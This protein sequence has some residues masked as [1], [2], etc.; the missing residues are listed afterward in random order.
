VA[1]SCSCCG[2]A[3]TH[4]FAVSYRGQ[5]LTGAICEEH[6]NVVARERLGLRDGR[7]NLGM[8]KIRRALTDPN[9]N[10]RFQLILDLEPLEVVGE[11][12]V[13]PSFGSGFSTRRFRSMSRARRSGYRGWNGQPETG[14]V[15]L[16]RV[17]D[18]D[19]QCH[20]VDEYA[21]PFEIG[22]KKGSDELLTEHGEPT[23]LADPRAAD[24]EHR[25]IA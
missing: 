16:I 9:S 25:A 11:G 22:E 21:I 23:V 2:N 14:H 24:Q 7:R 13:S 12:S 19:A 6:G 1:Q 3:A 18:T 4:R 10:P 17:A 20:A 5:T 15:E 8:T